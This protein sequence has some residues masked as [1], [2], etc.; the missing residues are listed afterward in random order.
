MVAPVTTF[1]AVAE[2]VL[3]RRRGA[4]ASPATRRRLGAPI[5]VVAL[6]LLGF[7]PAAYLARLFPFHDWGWLPYWGFL[8]GVARRARPRRVVADEPVRH[9]DA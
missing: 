4:A 2:I 5:E 3:T 6:A 9:H 7:L 8:F 1:F